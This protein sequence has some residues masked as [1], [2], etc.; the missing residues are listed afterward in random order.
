M[1]CLSERLQEELPL[2]M[3]TMAEIAVRKEGPG[4][5]KEVADALML[6]RRREAIGEIM[7]GKWQF[8]MPSWSEMRVQERKAPWPQ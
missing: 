6:C 5:H 3:R 1:L 8:D 2:N 7:S 4:I